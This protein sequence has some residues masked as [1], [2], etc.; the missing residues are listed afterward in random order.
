MSKPFKFDLIEKAGLTQREFADLVGVSRVTVHGWTKGQEPRK[1]VH[2][3]VTNALTL[4]RAAIKLKL[5]PGTMPNPSR[6]TRQQ[7]ADYIRDT[8]RQARARLKE[9]QS[10]RK[11]GG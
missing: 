4:L 7:R 5:L 3:P 11:S 6:H 1:M 10:R 8:L 2:K 9:E